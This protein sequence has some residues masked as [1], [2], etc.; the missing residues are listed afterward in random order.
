MRPPIEQN[1]VI[2]SNQRFITDAE[3]CYSCYKPRGG[4][5]IRGILQ[6][7]NQDGSVTE[8]DIEYGFYY[9][10]PFIKPGDTPIPS[11]WLS[12]YD[13][14]SLSKAKRVQ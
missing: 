5:R 12:E 3:L 8:Q 7:Y 9:G 11:H 4:D 13:T 14:V 10:A 1:N 2:K 6:T